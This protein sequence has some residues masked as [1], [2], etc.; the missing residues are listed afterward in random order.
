MFAEF[1]LYVQRRWEYEK[2]GYREKDKLGMSM[3][4]QDEVSELVYFATLAFSLVM[5]RR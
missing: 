4:G 1:N 5:M 3:W 2:K